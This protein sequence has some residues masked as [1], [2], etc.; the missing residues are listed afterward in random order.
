MKVIITQ[1]VIVGRCFV[2]RTVSRY[3]IKT[4]YHRTIH[5]SVRESIASSTIVSLRY[6][7]PATVI[8]MMATSICDNETLLL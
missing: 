5:R 8:F 7:T 6:L 4:I 3:L 1:N 2:I